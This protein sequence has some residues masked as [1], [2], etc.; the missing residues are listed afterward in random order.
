MLPAED[1]PS[2]PTPQVESRCT[3]RRRSDPRLSVMSVIII[4][5]KREVSEVSE[6]L[7]T[8]LPRSA[9]NQIAS[10]RGGRARTTTA[11]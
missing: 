9:D 11:E 10:D 2:W 6:W 4:D 7:A 8:A 1:D 3:A 5:R